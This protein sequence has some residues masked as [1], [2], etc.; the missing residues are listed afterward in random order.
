MANAKIL[1]EAIAVILSKID[2][3]K[4]S[5]A[6]FVSPEA[7]ALALQ[8]KQSVAPLRSPVPD[9]PIPSQLEGSIPTEPATKQVPYKQKGEG[10]QPYDSLTEDDILGIAPSREEV[11]IP[12]RRSDD[13]YIEPQTKDL[14]AKEK[15]RLKSNKEGELSYKEQMDIFRGKP[16]DKKSVRNS[17]DDQAKLYESTVAR[18]NRNNPIED[19]AGE[20]LTLDRL[21]ESEQE[22]SRTQR[23]NPNG[24]KSNNRLRVSKIREN[25]QLDNLG[26]S[27]EE[28]RMRDEVNRIKGAVDNAK[29]TQ[30][31]KQ[32]EAQSTG[33]NEPIKEPNYEAKIRASAKAFGVKENLNSDIQDMYNRLDEMFPGFKRDTPN[34]NEFYELNPLNG[35]PI[36]GAKLKGGKDASMASRLNDVKGRMANLAE[37]ARAETDPVLLANIKR[38]LDKIDTEFF[39]TRSTQETRQMGSTINPESN[40]QRIRQF[41]SEGERFTDDFTTGEVPQ[42]SIEF[43]R[44][45]DELSQQRRIQAQ[46][47]PNNAKLGKSGELLGD[48]GVKELRNPTFP[49]VLNLGRHGT[50]GVAIPKHKGGRMSLQEIIQFLEQER[51]KVGQQ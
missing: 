2:D 23:A 48:D 30:A 4:S 29:R 24:R 32:L 39:G 19:P 9:Q 11:P 25:E 31:E 36:P 37:R 38:E 33:Q 15:K 6:P 44:S 17:I 22:L 12:Q 14:S 42:D 7:K 50:A 3:A 45:M 18:Q 26:M 8:R 43:S 1:Q 27:Q 13:V 20:K 21:L 40:V 41:D 28:M 5:H 10:A 35:K 34:G 49:N 46:Q 16:G 51:S 47:G